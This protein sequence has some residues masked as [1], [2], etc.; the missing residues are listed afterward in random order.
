MA[1]RLR[2]CFQLSSEVEGIVDE[3]MDNVHKAFA[4]GGR[5][6]DMYEFYQALTLETI[7]RSAMGADFR[8][9]KDIAKSKILHDVK[10]FFSLN[11]NILFV[12]F[13]KRYDQLAVP[14]HNLI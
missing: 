12:L 3:F 9:Q 2:I 11:L 14:Y 10:S 8:V 7:C 1:K 6:V 4:S 13:R 5:S